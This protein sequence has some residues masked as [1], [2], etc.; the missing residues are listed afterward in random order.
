MLQPSANP[1]ISLYL[2]QGFVKSLNYFLQPPQ[3]VCSESCPPGTR[4]ARKKGQP[5]CCF[6]CIPCSERKIS[7]TTSEYQKVACFHWDLRLCSYSDD[8]VLDPTDIAQILPYIERPTQC[9]GGE[10]HRHRIL[11]PE[12]SDLKTLALASPCEWARVRHYSQPCFSVTFQPSKPVQCR[13]IT[14]MAETC[15]YTVYFC[16]N[17]TI[18]LGRTGQRRK[19]GSP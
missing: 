16:N 2:R 14:I 8:T 18:I 11:V 9:W 17:V 1:S 15:Y 4:M 12:W 6:D 3:S 7:N 5:E 13:T 19:I 10:L